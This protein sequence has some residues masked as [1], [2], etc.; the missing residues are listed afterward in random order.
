MENTQPVVSIIVPIYNGEKTLTRCVKSISEQKFT[1]YELLLIN[2]GS[3]DKSLEICRELEKKNKRIRIIDKE[4]EGVS[5]TRN[6][7]IKEARGRYIQFIDCDDYVTNDYL[8]CLV[9]IMEKEQSDLVIAGYTR[10]KNG[11]VTKRVPQPMIF[12]N[13]NAF[14]VEF[15]NLYNQWFLNTPW[16]KLYR[17]EKIVNKFPLSMSLG[18]DL[19]FNLQYLG[20]CE[21]II[22]I[23]HAGYQY[24]I[25]NENSLAIQYRKDKFENSMLL[26][27]KVLAFSKEVLGLKDEKQ[28]NDITFLK[29]IRFSMKHLAQSNTVSKKEK[30]AQI[31]AWIQ[32]EEVKSAYERCRH[33]SKPD[34]LLKFLIR[35]EWVEIIYI[36]L[37]IM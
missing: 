23:D 29:E 13:L 14:S 3:T 20:C 12:E 2:D 22:V 36:L 8:D 21:K 11:K 9:Q 15:F 37:S 25:E 24:C 30:K 34:R 1:E 6:F 28:W 16:N 26:H 7:G 17:K 5:A 19:L 18:E 4:N 10:H 35:Q 27:K 33:L 31:G 32:M